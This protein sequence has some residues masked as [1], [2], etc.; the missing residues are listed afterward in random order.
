MRIRSGNCV[1]AHASGTWHAGMLRGK[2]GF[3]AI[4]H[5]NGEFAVEEPAGSKSYLRYRYSASIMDITSTYTPPAA[6]GRGTARMLADAAF[7]HARQQQWRI[8]P[9][10]SYIAETYAPKHATAQGYSLDEA[11]GLYVLS[12]HA[13]GSSVQ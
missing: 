9:T 8:K 12:P 1:T 5:T 6:R 10:C 2:R 13:A 11:E 3:S 4:V 7:Q